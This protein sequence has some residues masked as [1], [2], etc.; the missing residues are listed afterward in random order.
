MFN[1]VKIISIKNDGD[2][3]KLWPQYYTIGVADR[4]TSTTG[5]VYE[6]NPEQEKWT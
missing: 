1:G 6:Y 2:S 4:I 5:K 3:F